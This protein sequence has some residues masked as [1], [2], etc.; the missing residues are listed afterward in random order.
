LHHPRAPA[1]P[2]DYDVAAELLLLF[3]QQLGSHVVAAALGWASPALFRR[4]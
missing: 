1:L 2:S 4:E 3:P